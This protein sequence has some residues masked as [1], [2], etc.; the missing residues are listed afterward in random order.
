MNW[1]LNNR[2]LQLIKYFCSEFDDEYLESEAVVFVPIVEY[3]A[4]IFVLF[5][6]EYSY[7]LQSKDCRALLH[8]PAA[9][10]RSTIVGA[11]LFWSQSLN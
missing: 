11:A 10:D 8:V 4:I 6:V 2:A 5:G 7:L 9:S 1:T 3:E